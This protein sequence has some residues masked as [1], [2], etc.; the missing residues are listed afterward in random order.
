MSTILATE[1]FQARCDAALATSKLLLENSNYELRNAPI[2]SKTL[3]GNKIKE[4][5]KGNFEAQHQRFLASSSTATNIQQQQQKVAYSAPPVFKR[6]KQRTKPSRPKQTQ[7]YWPKS[8]TQSYSCSKK[9]YVKRSGILSSSPPLSKPHLPQSSENQLFPLPFLPCP[10]IPVGGRLAHFVEQWEEL[11]YNKLVFSI[12]RN[13]FKIPFK[14]IPPLLVVWISLS[15]SSSPLLREEI[16]ELLK[17]QAVERV[18]NPGTHG[19]CSRLFL[20]PKKT[21]KLRPVIDLSS[22]N[23]YISKQPFKM[24]TFKSVRQL[25]IVSDWAVSIDLTDAYLHVR[26]HQISRKYLRFVSE[27]Q[28][29]QFTALPFG[30]SL[31]LWIFTKL[32]EVIAAYLHQRAIS[33]FPYLDDWLIRDLIRK[34]LIS[35]T[36]YC[37][38]TV[39]N[40]GFIP[41]LKVRFDTSTEIHLYRYGI[42]DSTEYS[43]GTG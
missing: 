31:S 28:V 11:T 17:K 40:L 36:K 15:Q 21:G 42:S 13:G 6:P 19:F 23:Q 7:P 35:H 8:Q 10:D 22:L 43:Q 9:D 26:I 27:H 32:M 41:N 34:Q 16:V 4:V 18:Q 30:M 38:Q 14:S 5:A 24:E 39:Q 20:V 33:L 3:F 1:I 12:V 25:I 2:S 29:F 37:L